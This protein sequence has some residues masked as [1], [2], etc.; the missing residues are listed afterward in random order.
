MYTLTI[1]LK[2]YID[3]YHYTQVSYHY[4]LTLKE[5]L[6]SIQNH[7]THQTIQGCYLCHKYV[8]SRPP[9]FPPFLLLL[10]LRQ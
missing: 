5:S 6:H 9:F 3:N 1:M 2:L 8:R 10:Y 7:Q 4:S